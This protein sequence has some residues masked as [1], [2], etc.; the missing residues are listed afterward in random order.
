MA[1][2]EGQVLRT[3]RGR[4]LYCT[5]TTDERNDK[6]QELLAVLGEIEAHEGHTK[7]VKAGLKQRETT[8][9][10]RKGELVTL[11]RTGGE[12]RPTDVQ[13]VYDPDEKL[14]REVRLDTGAVVITRGPTADELQMKLGENGGK[15]KDDDGAAG[16]AASEPPPDDDGPDSDAPKPYT[17]PVGQL[18]APEKAKAKDDDAIDAEFIDPA[19]DARRFE[20]RAKLVAMSEAE[21]DAHFAEMPPADLRDMLVDLFDHP[22][23]KAAGRRALV[24]LL[25]AKIEAVAYLDP[26]DEP[27]EEED[28]DDE[29]DEA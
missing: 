15:P 10:S 25:K 27:E 19:T 14:V 6:Q 3:E 8:L 7:D 23:S 4:K 5:L 18:P 22:V 2:P 21:L 16:A 12:Y 11:L 17:A 1:E 9:N 24:T 20:W 29:G 28:D 13:V 26:R